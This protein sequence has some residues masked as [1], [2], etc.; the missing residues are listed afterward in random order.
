MSEI[1]RESLAKLRFWE[2]STYQAIPEKM[3]KNVHCVYGV[4]ALAQWNARGP[5][6]TWK[7]ACALRLRVNSMHIHFWQVKFPRDD[8]M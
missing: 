5:L 7:Q 6:A 4:A 8:E 3:T 1:P 2:E